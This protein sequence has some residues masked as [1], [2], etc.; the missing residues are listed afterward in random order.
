MKNKGRGKSERYVKLRLWL[1]DAPAWKSLPANA[2]ALYIEL[3]RRYNGSNN[4]RISYSVREAAQALRVSLSTASH[5]LRILQ[6]RRFIVCTKRGA[7]SLKTT[8]DASEWQ[9]TEYDCDHPVAHASKDF[10][11]WR[12]PE[13]V[14]F[15]TLNRQPSHHRKFKTR[16]PQPKHTVTPAETHG[17]PSRSISS[18]KRKDDYPSRSIRAKNAPSTVTPAEHLQL[19]G[20]GREP[21][22][23]DLPSFLEGEPAAKKPWST[24][25]VVPWDTLPT[26]LR[27]L[28][29]DLPDPEG[30]YG[31]AEC[32][33]VEEAY[34][35]SMEKQ[36]VEKAPREA[37]QAPDPVPRQPVL[38]M[39]DSKEDA[40][41]PPVP[42]PAMTYDEEVAEIMRRQMPEGNRRRA[43][44]EAK[45]REMTRQF[46]AKIREQQ[47]PH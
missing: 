23:R 24:P 45:N 19:P 25:T 9:L 33:Q 12:P 11:R 39:Q 41:I 38:V 14:D 29:L 5:L 44:N 2:R 3:A 37:D 13:G 36:P 21:G 18:K 46:D 34:R 31:R 17:C 28:A 1:L 20:R 16:L 8:K 43:L 22:V 35:A 7:F 40:G 32:G 26:E 10:M 4:G 6:D 30:C 27:M 42:P 47:R 15:A